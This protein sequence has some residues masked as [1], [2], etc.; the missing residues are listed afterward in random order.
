MIL[1][2]ARVIQYRVALPSMSWYLGRPIEEV[3][4]APVLQ[5]RF[6]R[7]GETLVLLRAS[8]Y[9]SIKALAPT[10]IVDRRPLFDVKLRSVLEGTAMPEM[11]LISNR[12]ER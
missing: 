9:E 11:L 10:C 8:D 7:P 1:P 3:L 12:C 6:S 5:E 4:D 2:G